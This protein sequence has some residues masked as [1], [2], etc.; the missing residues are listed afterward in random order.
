MH[1]LG[2]AYMRCVCNMCGVCVTYVYF[3]CF[4]VLWC[5]RGVVHVTSL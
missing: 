1:V 3:V 5:V 2:V 4:C